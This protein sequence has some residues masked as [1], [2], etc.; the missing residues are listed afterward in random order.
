MDRGKKGGVVTEIEP[1]SISPAPPVRERE[2]YSTDCQ[3]MCSF[4]EALPPG[5]YGASAVNLM[6]F[7]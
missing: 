2:Q 5:S 7:D 3:A 1:P 4:L 6:K